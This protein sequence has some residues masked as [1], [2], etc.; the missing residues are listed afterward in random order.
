MHASDNTVGT[1]TRY[2]GLRFTGG[3]VARIRKHVRPQALFAGVLVALLAACGTDSRTLTGPEPV[4]DPNLQVII[5]P[6]SGVLEICKQATTAVPQGTA[7]QFTVAAL[8][9]QT[10]TVLAGFCTPPIVVVAGTHTITELGTAFTIQSVTTFPTDRF[11]AGSLTGN[12][13]QVRVPA[14]DIGTQTVVFVTNVPS[15]GRLKI[16]KT[17]GPGVT[18]G[19]VFAFT[20]RVVATGATTTYSVPAGQCVVDGTFPDSTVVE[21]TETLPTGVVVRPPIDVAPAG[22]LRTCATP[23][24]NR[25]CAHIS[26]NLITE[27]TFTNVGVGRLKICKVSTTFPA[28]TNFTFTVRALPSGTPTTYTVPVG[29]CI[30]DGEFPDSTV[31]EITETLPTLPPNQRIIVTTDVA[32]P[33]ELRTCAAPLANRA[34]AH[35]SANLI[36][37]VTFTNTL[38]EFPP[39]GRLDICKA[40]TGLSGSWTFTITGPAILAGEPFTAP[41]SPVSVAAGQCVTVGTNLKPGN[42]TIVEA[43]RTGFACV[44][45]TTAPPGALVSFNLATCTAVVTVTSGATTT[46]TFTNRVVRLEGCTPGYWKNHPESWVGFTTGQTLESV[47]DVPNELGL[48]NATLLEALSFG[49]GPGVEGASQI[50]LRAAVAALL[51][52]ASPGV[53]YPLTTAQVIAQVNA[54]L[55]TGDRATILALAAE[56]DRLNNLGCPLN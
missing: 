17:A 54:A 27:V 4:V 40:G 30:V 45:A 15:E 52:S 11:V 43:S 20:V 1:T 12:T 34:C 3:S 19:T 35:I 13:F 2:A 22:E 39:P 9:G 28:G 32:P 6:G 23:L 26:G 18:A 49:G 41:T 51:N 55:A 29:Q 44:S 10:F 7:F 14:G 8:P 48:D 53:D 31:V 21:I 33:G 24:P 37:E 42:F 50:L 46:V 47:F 56:L 38:Q 25:V 36:T 5:P 16:C